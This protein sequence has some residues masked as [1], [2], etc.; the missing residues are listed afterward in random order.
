MASALKSKWPE[1]LLIDIAVLGGIWCLSLA[2]VFVSKGRPHLHADEIASS[3]NHGLMALALIYVLSPRF[4]GRGY[5]IAFVLAV[6]ALFVVFGS[7]EEAVLEPLFDPEDRGRHGWSADGVY[8]FLTESVP[9]VALMFIAKLVIDQRRAQEALERL[10]NEQIESELKFLRSQINPHI[11]FNGLNNIFSYA[12]TS[13]PQTPD[14]LLKLSDFL[15]YTLYECASDSVPL[16]QEL[17]TVR[18]YVAL[19][20][21]GLEGRGQVTF[22]IQGSLQHKSVIPFVLITLIENCFKHSLDTQTDSIRIAIFILVEDTHIEMNTE[23][24]FIRDTRSAQDGVQEKGVG[25]GNVRRR[26]ELLFPNRYILEANDDNTLFRTRLRMPLIVE[27][28]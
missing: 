14:M 11:L 13:H 4:L 3:V 25:L 18:N 24:T 27:Q 5:N 16:E 21:M 7:F 9:L 26:L 2:F 28:V 22:D 23:N 6:A 15:R 1:K 20:E 12:L 19:Q 17:A 8:D 10:R